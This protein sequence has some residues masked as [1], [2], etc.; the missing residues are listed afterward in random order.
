MKQ[1]IKD[2]SGLMNKVLALMVCCILLVAMPS[3]Q[4]AMRVIPEAQLINQDGKNVAF[5]RE[6]VQGKTAVVNFIFTSCTMICPTQTATLRQ[7]QRE[8]GTRV[9]RDVVF[10]SISID[11]NTD[12]PPRLK[13]FAQ[14]FETGPGWQFLTGNK[15]VVDKL[16][17]SL[18]AGVGDIS[19]HSGLVLVINEK[20]QVWQQLASMPE[21][22]LIQSTV[23]QVAGPDPA[24]QAAN[25]RYFPNLPL[26]TQDGK[27]VHFFDDVMKDKVVLINF[28]FTTCPGICS[29]MTANLAR[30]QPL[31]DPRV[32]MV[33]I[34]VD[35]DTDTPKVLKDFAS[36]FKVRPGW[37]FLTGSTENIS[38]VAKKLG[39]SGEDKDAHSGILLAGN[40][41]TG[42]WKKIHATARPEDIALAVG[43]LLP[44][45]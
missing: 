24:M 18:H 29:P 4:A 10:I 31:L 25:G 9:G 45:R 5:Y 2:V 21:A 12:N 33:S 39:G 37:L 8:L 36:K 42:D 28:I 40:V 20:K 16:L 1:V 7:V 22:K 34:T 38:A 15:A 27:T 30:V 43:K 6:L 13:A 11:P 17:R 14:Q 35:P 23:E 19:N 41:Q 44:A 32:Q 26:Q 3:A